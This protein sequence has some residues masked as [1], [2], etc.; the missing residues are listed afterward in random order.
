[1]QE[2]YSK[3]QQDAP[4]PFIDRAGCRNEVDIEEAMFHALLGEQQKAAAR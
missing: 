4:N 1:M 3:L 2:K